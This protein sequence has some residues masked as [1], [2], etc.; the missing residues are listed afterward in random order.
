MPDFAESSSAAG[1]PAL[2]IA[3]LNAKYSLLSF[4]Q[5]IEQ[6]YH[7]FDPG[8]V[9]VTSS[10]AATSAYFL[11]IISRI[12]PQQTIFFI[13]TGYHFPET[14][15]YKDYLSELYRLV[16]KDVRPEEWKHEFTARD[17]TY[18]SDP[19]FCC[20][21]NK[22]EPLDEVKKDY[23]VWVSSL[24]RWQTS[25]RAGLEIF[26]ERGGVIKFYPMVDVGKDERDAYIREHQL[27]F[28]PLVARGYSSVGCS[29]CTVPGDDRAGRWVDTPK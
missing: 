28:H 18:K 3:A 16:V 5:R 21:V 11:H 27:P 13:D 1:T 29:H 8:T 12:R 15:S 6:L 24:M 20:S 10:F 7:D 4:A 14:L 22:V 17:E 9:M 19:D 26:E 2:E 23:R 25:H